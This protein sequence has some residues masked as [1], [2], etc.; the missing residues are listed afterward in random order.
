MNCLKTVSVAREIGK[1]RMWFL[2]AMSMLAYF[3]IFYTMFQTFGSQIPLADYGFFP[4][5]LGIAA[6]IPVHLILHCLPIWAAGK[7][8]S[9]G[10]RKSQWPYFYYS[11]KYPLTKNLSMFSTIF[12]ALSVTGAA[13]IL[14]S[15]F[16]A[17]THYIAI[18]SALNFGLS[19]YDFFAFRQMFSAP[20]A[21]LI[22]ENRNGFHVIKPMAEQEAK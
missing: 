12:P 11:A 22:E 13:I 9:F 4:V 18:L 17:Q 16:P 5:I 15:I 20:H 1:T 10:Y 21:S 8:A 3:L 19:T 6:V 7:Q 2:S 14:A